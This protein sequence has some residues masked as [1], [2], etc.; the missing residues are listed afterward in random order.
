MADLIWKDTFLPGTVHIPSGDPANPIRVETFTPAD[1]RNACE[2]GNAKLAE[3]WQIPVC[4]DHQPATEPVQMSVADRNAK[5]AK[6]TFT[7]VRAYRLGSEG[8]LQSGVLPRDPKDTEQM[9]KTGF[10]SPRLRWNWTD[11]TGKKWPGWTVGHVAVTPY[12]VQ[13]TQAP[14]DMSR[15][16]A[17]RPPINLSLG[18]YMADEKKKPEDDEIPGNA[19]ATTPEGDDGD[20]DSTLPPLPDEASPV[21]GLPAP[22][23][24][25][26][27]PAIAALASHGITL[28]PDTNAANFAERINIAI[29]A[30]AG[31]QAKKDAEDAADKQED[32]ASP[33]PNNPDAMAV[34]VGGQTPTESKQ[35][36]PVSMSLAEQKATDKAIVL[37]RRTITQRINR[38]N[39]TGRITPVIAQKL[40]AEARAVNLSFAESGELTPNSVTAKI[41]AYEALPAQSA[42]SKTGRQAADLSRAAVVNP[43]APTP[44]GM[45]DEQF[46]QQWGG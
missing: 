4:W 43:P 22:E 15:A 41:D 12:P 9:K 13:H 34:K 5:I 16:D 8:Q 29:T 42:W 19:D 17:E 14:F 2:V 39:K 11:P 30:I 6:N 21:A 35:P 10:V 24:V 3:G 31:H 25:H 28:P 40:L 33:D 27:K 20:D 32:D 1:V 7:F 44:D 45:T 38:L 37:E 26:L 18:D 46:L 23:D 36:A